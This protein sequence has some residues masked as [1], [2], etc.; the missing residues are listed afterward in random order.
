[1]KWFSG[2]GSLLGPE[3]GDQLGGRRGDR[4]GG[5]E[6]LS[7]QSHLNLNIWMAVFSFEKLLVFRLQ[8]VEFLYFQI[9]CDVI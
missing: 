7:L 3:A 2:A 1:M 4:G 5:E 6:G 9:W 8:N